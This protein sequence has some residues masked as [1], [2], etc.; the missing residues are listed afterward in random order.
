MAELN[1]D[2]DSA[3]ETQPNAPIPRPPPQ[4]VKVVKYDGDSVEALIKSQR[5]NAQYRVDARR[6]WKA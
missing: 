6:R 5:G 3:D 1:A 4:L 2:A